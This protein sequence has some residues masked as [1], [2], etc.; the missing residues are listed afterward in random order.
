[1]EAVAVDDGLLNASSHKLTSSLFEF[2]HGTFLPSLFS[3]R[4]A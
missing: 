2:F 1:M 3:K 4:F